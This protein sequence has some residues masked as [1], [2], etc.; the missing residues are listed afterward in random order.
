MQIPSLAEIRLIWTIKTIHLS[1]RAT[2]TGHV[3]NQVRRLVEKG[4]HRAASWIICWPLCWSSSVVVAVVA[5]TSRAQV[6][7]SKGKE[8]N[9]NSR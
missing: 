4:S 3:S 5:P 7:A 2:T 6:E 9:N 1:R 8:H